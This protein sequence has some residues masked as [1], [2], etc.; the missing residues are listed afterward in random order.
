MSPAYCIE[1][2]RREVRRKN[3]LMMV[4][5]THEVEFEYNRMNVSRG[6][7]YLG[8]RLCLNLNPD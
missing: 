4:V 6:Q 7:K 2:P 3:Q 1:V 5:C 8:T